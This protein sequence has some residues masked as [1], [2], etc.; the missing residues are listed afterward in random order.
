MTQD[1]RI[2]RARAYCVQAL[3]R[4]TAVEERTIVKQEDAGLWVSLRRNV[5][6]AADELEQ[7]ARAAP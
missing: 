2:A 5:E 4:L 3:E 6:S 1:E 7:A